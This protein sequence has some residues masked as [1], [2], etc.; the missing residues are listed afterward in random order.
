MKFAG[1]G[2]WCSGSRLSLGRLEGGAS[3]SAG[4]GW[5]CGDV[6]GLCPMATDQMSSDWSLGEEVCEGWSGRGGDK[7]VTMGQVD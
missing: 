3:I 4:E 7:V 5:V 6:A 2:L 1:T